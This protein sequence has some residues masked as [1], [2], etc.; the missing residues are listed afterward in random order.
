MPNM[1]VADILKIHG[2]W[3]ESKLLVS[4]ITEKMR[5]D[6]RQAYRIIKEAYKN[7]EIRK[8]QLPD[9]GILYGLAEFGPISSER[10][11]KSSSV[12]TLDFSDAFLYSSFK[13]LEEISA[14]A[15]GNPAGAFRK[16]MFFVATLPKE[17]KEKIK[18]FQDQA[19]DAVTKKRKGRWEPRYGFDQLLEA[20]SP[21]VE[22]MSECYREALKL[23]NEIS[24][25]LHE[26]SK[27]EKL[28]LR[29]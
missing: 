19:L 27:K 25:L 22:F 26:Y 15:E 6:E 28:K 4:L 7:N 21:N 3:T 29:K 8:V 17:L 18:A 16:L 12:K 2:K 5:I 14:I 11:S 20:D 23:I 24:S 10:A 13:K 9:R 1:T